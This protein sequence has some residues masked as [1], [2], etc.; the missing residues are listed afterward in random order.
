MLATL[1]LSAPK[2]EQGGLKP[3]AQGFPRGDPELL[4]EAGDTLCPF[5]PT[6]SVGRMELGKANPTWQAH[7][8]WAP[9]SGSSLPCCVPTK[10]RQ[11]VVP[12]S[13]LCPVQEGECNIWFLPFPHNEK[14]M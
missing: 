14:E 1:T 3:S 5:P 12:R 2:P 11:A 6:V 10:G 7:W 8:R 4:Q 9:L 13:T